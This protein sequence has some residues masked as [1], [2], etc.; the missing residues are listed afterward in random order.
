MTAHEAFLALLKTLPEPAAQ[1][2]LQLVRSGADVEAVV[3]AAEAGD[4]IVQLALTPETRLRY[5]LPYTPEIPAEYLPNNPYLS[6]LIYESAS[7]YQT[8]DTPK[9]LDTNRDLQ[10]EELNTVYLRPFHAAQVFDSQVEDAKFSS[11][12][13]VCSN[14]A[15][16]REIFKSLLRC[17]YNFTAAFQKDLF[18]E[19]LTSKS[20]D[21]CSSMLVN[22]VLG[23]ACV[24]VL[25]SLPLC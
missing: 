17:E 14:D 15:L 25:L 22:A 1:S 18:L 4:P 19:D 9:S 20:T 24:S 8:K 23:Y 2:F 13:T 10:S 7:L 12:T 3:K 16:M 5:Q 11:W 21:F 6:S